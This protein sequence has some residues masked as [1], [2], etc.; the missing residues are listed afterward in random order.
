MAE[1]MT[2]DQQIDAE[3]PQLPEALIDWLAEPFKRLLRIE[4]AAGLILLLFTI[5]ALVLS[6]SSW[7]HPFI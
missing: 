1:N 7:V 2:E 3:N 6:N 4:A 5:A